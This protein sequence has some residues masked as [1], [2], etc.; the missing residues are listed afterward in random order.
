MGPIFK[1]A[2]V[3]CL[4]ALSGLE[5]ATAATPPQFTVHDAGEDAYLSVNLARVG[6]MSV[7]I[8]QLTKDDELIESVRG[9]LAG[10]DGE[11][12]VTTCADTIS[13]LKKQKSFVAQFTKEDDRNYRQS[14][15]EALTTGLKL[16]ESY[17]T[18]DDEW[19]E[20]WKKPD[21]VNLASLL[22]SNS[23][24]IGCAVGICTEGTQG[25]RTTTK[26]AYLFCQMD[27]AAEENKAPFDKEYY[28]ALTARKTL[29]TAMTEEDLKTPS[30]GAAPVAV[31]SLVLAGL[32][33]IVALAS[34]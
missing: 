4:V 7:R 17:P 23:T 8:S 28:E 3:A 14:V 5:P 15:Q 25:D 1:R 11:R 6:Q 27:P 31:P 19:K 16:M 2:A 26:T 24:N 12:T 32:T 18:T 22:W 10:T 21:G 34:A 33:A 30:N 9:T 20:L 13:E 29:L